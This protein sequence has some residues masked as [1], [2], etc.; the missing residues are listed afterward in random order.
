MDAP[1]PVRSQRQY[2]PHPNWKNGDEIVIPLLSG[3]G[4]SIGCI[5][6]DDPKD[7][8]RLGPEEMSKMELLAA[9]LG[10][11]VENS[12]LQR[13]LTRSEKL[14]SI[15]QLVAGVAHELNNP[16]TAVLGYSELLAEEVGSESALRKVDS[17]NREAQ[18]MK[19]IIQNL[20]RFARQN[21]PGRQRVDLLGLIQ[22]VLALREYHLN[23]RAVRLEI[24]AADNL[25]PVTGDEDQLKQVVMNVLN[26]AVDAVEGES[27]RRIS[28]ELLARR[29]RV[30]IEVS[31]NGCGFAEPD[32]AFDPFYTTK[33]VGK[34][35]GLGLSICYGILKEHG[36]E[37][38]VAN[39]QPRGARVTIE[40]PA[41][42]NEGQ[43]A[44]LADASRQ[45]S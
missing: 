37:I 28:I 38:Q 36:G 8:E 45:G 15:G 29:E 19:R 17:L 7:V 39:L 22:D 10:V 26:N 27:E 43:P 3:Q 35:T 31:D 23:S 44:A 20:L 9:D 12:T 30:A 6:L 11:A 33:P 24:K 13:Q 16:L 34:G 4:R 25:P 14:A 2:P 1:N 32:R 18:R 5:S 21:K 41:R 42:E 40:L